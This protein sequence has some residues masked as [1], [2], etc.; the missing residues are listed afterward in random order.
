[1]QRAKSHRRHSA[2]HLGL[3]VVL[4]C[5]VMVVTASPSPVYAAGSDCKTLSGW[6]AVAGNYIG[7]SRYRDCR[8][9]IIPLPVRIEQY[10]SPG[11]WLTVASGMGDVVYT[12]NGSGY[13]TYRIPY[14]TGPFDILCG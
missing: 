8:G 14:V 12:C 3:A 6:D 1:M 5:L 7:A 11:V 2:T 13:N 4:F 10:Q 9:T